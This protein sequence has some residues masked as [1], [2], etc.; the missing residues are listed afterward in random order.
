MA[1]R[2]LMVLSSNEDLGVSGMKTGNWAHEVATAYYK[3]KDAGINVT[4][5]SPKGGAAPMDPLSLEDE[6]ASD[7]V[8]QFEAEVKSQVVVYRL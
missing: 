8:R 6:W 3:F 5:A 1:K 2:V 4:M 7:Y